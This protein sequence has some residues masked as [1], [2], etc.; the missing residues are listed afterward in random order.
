MNRDIDTLVL[1]RHARSTANEDDLVYKTTP[2]HVI[3]LL[4]PG[5]DPAA[6]EAGAKIAALGLD[7]S[8]TCCWCSPYLRCRQTEAIVV[9]RAFGEAAH[10]IDRRESFLLREQEFGDW[11]G[12]SDQEIAA[13][14]PVRSARYKLMTDA[15]GQFYFRLPN[16]ESRADV[17]ERVTLFIGK[18]HRSQF[19]NHII[20]S[21]GVTQRALRMSWHNR[22][23][24][25]FESERNPVNAS[26]LVIR[27][28]ADGGWTEEYL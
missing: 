2:D 4:R 28:G 24:D 25:W 3:P 27:R 7:A 15:R 5:S 23:V 8:Q 18:L 14:D 9:P 26:V 10:A 6:L 12:L 11:D 13:S 17:V 19:R 16:G 1:V 20:T 21:H 22:S